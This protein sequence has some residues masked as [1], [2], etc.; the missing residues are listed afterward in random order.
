MKIKEALLFGK[1]KL[2]NADITEYEYDAKEILSKASGIKTMEFFLHYDDELS[3]E[4]EHLFLTLIEK[5]AERIPLQLLFGT[6]EFMGYSFGVSENVLIPRIDTE[7]LC[8]EAEKLSHENMRFL[9]ICTGTGCIP[10][11]LV[12]RI[13]GSKAI[14]IDISDYAI[15]LSK[16]NAG[17]LGADCLFYHGDLYDALP[18]ELPE[19]FSSDGN[20]EVKF[21]MI[22][23]NP[24][25]IKSSEIENLMPEVKD[26]EPHLALDGGD[27]GLIFYRRITKD[28]GKYLKEN[29]VLLFE[30]GYDEGENVVNIMKENGFKDIFLKKDLSGN[31]RVVGGYYY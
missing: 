6:Q 21:D 24:P 19:D 4:D 30:I 9:D 1:E 28:A 5:R 27:D 14:G 18:D 3:K 15:A 2:K 16:K 11:A 22:I 12:K 26:H 17:D 23:S 8:E 31:D 7:T 29:G 10:I 20:R 25:Y 13:K